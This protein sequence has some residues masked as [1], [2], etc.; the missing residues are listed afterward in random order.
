MIGN[1]FLVDTNIVIEVFKGNQEIADYLYKLPD[2]YI[3]SI[4]LGELYTGIN[5]VS[6]RE[7][8]LKRLN[9]FL[10][11]TTIL[12]VDG[13]TAAIYGEL[14]ADLYKLGKPIPTNDVWIAAIAIQY[15]LTLLTSDRHFEEINHLKSSYPTH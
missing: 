9:D 10:K 8:H 6:N 1:N 5:R 7:K 12:N 14:I 15:N 11:L 3:S 4:A 2:I 13:E